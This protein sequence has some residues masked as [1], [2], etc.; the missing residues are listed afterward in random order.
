MLD[1]NTSVTEKCEGKKWNIMPFKKVKSKI[2]FTK[3]ETL[4]HREN[5]CLSLAIFFLHWL[6]SK[7]IV[8]SVLKPSARL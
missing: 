5:E 3:Y 4:I 8:E 1:E 6:D 7:G 2:Q